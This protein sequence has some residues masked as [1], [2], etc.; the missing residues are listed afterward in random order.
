MA[1]HND[2]ECHD[3]NGYDNHYTALSRLLR[4]LFRGIDVQCVD[5]LDLRRLLRLYWW[6]N[7]ATIT[8]SNNSGRSTGYNDEGV[9]VLV[10]ELFDLREVHLARLHL[11]WVRWLLT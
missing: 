11:W 1:P 7:A 6:D 3:F 10:H 2:H 9:S 8:G 4:L 5:G